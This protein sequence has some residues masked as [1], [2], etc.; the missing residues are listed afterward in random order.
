[1]N[2]FPYDNDQVKKAFGKS[3]RTLRLYCGFTL[4]DM[5]KMTEINNP[6]LSR[7]ENGLVEPSL[8]QAIII[9]NTFEL[10]AEDFV[11]FGLGLKPEGSDCY[12]IIDYFNQRLADLISE[13]GENAE[14]IFR[15]VFTKVDFDA[16]IKNYLT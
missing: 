16:L 9:A 7:Y 15:K 11:L 12:D 4:N 1:M 6:S 13:M 10:K 8:T 2:L 3:F 5:E 14:K